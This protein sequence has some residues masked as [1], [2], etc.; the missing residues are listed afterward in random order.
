MLKSGV[1]LAELTQQMWE[2]NH[3][4]IHLLAPLVEEILCTAPGEVWTGEEVRHLLNQRLAASR[5]KTVEEHN[6]QFRVALRK[7]LENPKFFW[8]LD[9]TTPEGESKLRFGYS[10][11]DEAVR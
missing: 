6:F 4:R 3:E 10:L 2:E 1:S 11:K 5:Q 9:E 7:V 8:Y